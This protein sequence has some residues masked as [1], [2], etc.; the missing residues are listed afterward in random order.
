ME[1]GRI[2]RDDPFGSAEALAAQ[3]LA[4]A[5]R[6]LCLRFRGR[7]RPEPY[8]VIGGVDRITRRAILA[9]SRLE[10]ADEFQVFGGLDAL[11]VADSDVI[12]G[13]VI[14]SECAEI[15]FGQGIRDDRA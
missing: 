6:L 1:G 11:G 13:H 7:L 10:P 12:A 14:R 9:E 3:E 4:N 8:A 5:L 2:D 15:V